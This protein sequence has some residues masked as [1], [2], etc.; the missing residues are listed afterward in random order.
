MLKGNRKLNFGNSLSPSGAQNKAS[1]MLRVENKESRGQFNKTHRL[2][3][4]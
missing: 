2:L 4:A 3:H 1:Q